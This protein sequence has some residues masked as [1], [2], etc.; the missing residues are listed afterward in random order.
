M[1]I[2]CILIISLFSYG[3]SYAQLSYANRLFEEQDYAG[4]IPLYEKALKK[5]GGTVETYENLAYCYKVINDYK[6]AE[7]YYEQAVDLPNVNSK[8]H[9][10]YG[11]VLKS[12]NKINLAREQFVE[13]S[14]QEPTSLVGKLMIQSCD[15]IAGW[16]ASPSKF[17][18]ENLEI[19]NSEL[20]DFNAIAYKNG[21]A[22]TSSKNYIDWSEKGQN[23]EKYDGIINLLYVDLSADLMSVESF[24]NNINTKSNFEGPGYLSA[25]QT[26]LAYVKVYDRQRNIVN[27]LEIHFA[28]F[29]DGE[30]QNDKSM[31]LNSKE[32]SYNN[33][34]LS[35]DAKR[36]YFASDI[37]GGYG[38]MDIYY[39]DFVDG[40]WTVPKNLGPNINSEGLE[41]PSYIDENDVLYFSSN[42]YP[43]YGG[44]DIFKASKAADWKD[45]E[46]LKSPYN[47]TKDD[48]G[49]FRVD[50]LNGYFS[51]NRDGGLGKDDI[52]HVFKIPP[53]DSSLYTD[54]TGLFQFDELPALNTTLN[55]LDENDE[56]VQITKTDENGEFVFKN[57]KINKN[58]RIVVD[59]KD[60]NIPDNATLFLTNSAKEKV[61]I[62]ERLKKGLFQFEALSMQSYDELP[63]LEENDDELLDKLNLIGQLYS[64][65]PADL[66]EG[67]EV[68][69]LDDE[70]L[71]IAT[72]KTDKFGRFE[73]KK[74]PVQDQFLFQLEED[75]PNLAIKIISA[76]GKLIG[77]T[78]KNADGNFVYYKFKKN[79]SQ[80]PDIRGLFKYG[81][82]PADDVSLN[83]LNE[84]DELL[85]STRTNAKGEFEFNNLAAGE[86]YHIQVDESE[87]EVPE[88]AQLFIED[89]ITGLNLPVS[90]LQNGKFAF[91]TL[92][93]LE[94]EELTLM[95]AEDEDNVQLTIIA[96]AFNKLPLDLSEDM[97]LFLVDDEGTV[98]AKAIADKYGKFQFDKLPLE[99]DYLFKLSEDDENLNL[100]IVNG[101]G[102][103]LATT[104]RDEQ[105]LFVYHRVNE[106]K[107]AKRPNILGLFKYGELPA[108]DVM[109]NLLNEDDDI[110]QFVRT[111]KEGKF[112][113]TNLDA[114]S[115]YRIRVDESEGEVPD[116]A[117]MFLTDE[118]TGMTLPVRLLG[119][120]DFEFKTLAYIE[121]GE[122]ALQE[123]EDEP[124]FL[125]FKL[126]GQLFTLLPMTDS[127]LME[128]YVIDEDGAV[129]A[130]TR[131]DQYGRFAFEKLPIQ[132]EYLLKIEELEDDMRL[133]ITDREGNHIQELK[134]NDEGIFVYRRTD[135]DNV[136]VLNEPK[137]DKPTSDTKPIKVVEAESLVIPTI[138][139]G[140]D[141]WELNNGAREA[142]DKLADL[143]K[144]N[145]S[146]RVELNSHT[147]SYGEEVYNQYLSHKRAGSAKK[148][149]VTKGI[150]SNR[151]DAKGFGSS[152]LINN[153]DKNTPCSREQH[154]ANRRTE[155]KIFN[156]K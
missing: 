25:D 95:H 36:L 64:K 85:M 129:I 72:A 115:D 65:L 56:L 80:N 29:V 145:A 18:S 149:L 17:E 26:L 118:A 113:F 114:G 105:G 21:V 43:G 97:T 104:T 2:I 61:A 52:Y 127:P 81:N 35:H 138:Q 31:T 98:L 91:E 5:N 15:D 101:Q 63:L 34:V 154:A 86:T 123:E 99:D 108:E 33:P 76:E 49:Y 144:S 74:L 100:N 137:K 119:N 112:K 73:F 120:G 53:E 131:T 150:A 46:N 67:M 125:R 87:G 71:I 60:E 23:L 57:V 6:K 47:S 103:L 32:Y 122:L 117:Q 14:K 37:E 28:R 16:S 116:N 90:R 19:V 142:L 124:G 92:S 89:K 82:L 140:F 107:T 55:L 121:E 38:G 24:S 44:L 50:S 111:D 143:M 146:V 110:V 141:S 13:Y 1:R 96:Q 136:I 106:K 148:Y 45:I 139:Y 11:Q 130:M 40:E 39:A 41:I 42:Y 30:W 147:D 155:V 78:Q 156:F 12:N 152:Q 132:D 126:F 27:Q 77:T 7:E 54:I 133:S 8:T 102:E 62:V 128:I 69:L 75:D 84:E 68:Y 151:I 70:G 48:F 66:P 20:E 135:T 22:F 94:G 59:E 79:P 88:N 4:A 109:L 83:L 3:Y 134:K 58:Y 153:C 10:Y 51:S 9:L 93:Y